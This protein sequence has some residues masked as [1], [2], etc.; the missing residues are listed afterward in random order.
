MLQLK[1]LAHLDDKALRQKMLSQ[2]DIRLFQ[3]WQIIHC[4]QTNPGKKAEEYASL[5]GIAKEKV[6]RITQQ[7]NKKGKDLDVE[8]QWG[9]R[10]EKRSL[11]SLKEEQQMMKGLEKEARAGKI[12]T[13]NDM[14]KVVEKK[15]GQAVSDDYLW[16]LFKRHNWKKKA[17][18]PQYPKKQ[19]IKQEEFKKNSPSFWSPASPQHKNQQNYFLKMR[20][21]LEE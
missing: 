11:L 14:R 2:N 6:Y 18:R 21:D 9:G 7:Y 17:P 16:D 1:T 4:V 20:Q 3:Y 10:R 19:P 13:M 12:I 5:L 15:A 8:F